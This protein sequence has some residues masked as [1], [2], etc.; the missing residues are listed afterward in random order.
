VR[1]CPSLRI[2]SI[3]LGLGLALG[4]PTE[5][6]ARAA[7]EA[8][9]D[10]VDGPIRY[11]AEKAEVQL[12]RQLKSDEA[13]A[14]FIER[15]WARRDPSPSSLSNEYRQM[16]W[17]RVR[18][19]NE[20]FLDSPRPGCMTDRGKI[21]VLY[22]PPTKIEEH[23]NLDTRSSPTAG[24]G[25]IR[26]VYEGRPGG[27]K[28]L[29]PVVIVPFVR[30]ATGEYRV[31]YDPK[32]SSV[33]FDALAVEERWDHA[34]DRF[35]EIFGAP[36]AT[37]MSVMLDLGRMQE[38]PPQA[39]VLL[40]RVET[41]EAYATQP[42]EVRLSRFFHPDERRDLVVV[43]ADVT[44]V[45]EGTTPV[46]VARFAPRDAARPQRMLGEDVFRLAHGVGRRLAQGRLLLDPGTYDLTVLVVDPATSVTG[47]KRTSLTLPEP[48]GRLRLSDLSWAAEL[49]PVEYG[50]LAS[51]DEPFLVGP[52]RVVPRFGDGF[53]LGDSLKLFYE[54]YGGTPPYRIAYQVEG[55]DLDGSWVELGRPAMTEQSAAG[56]GWELPTSSSWPLG[57]YRIRVDVEDAGRRSVSARLPFRLIAAIR[58]SDR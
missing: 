8:F 20:L 49:S 51:Y 13:R 52:F 10:W 6:P 31:S 39:R 58:A 9:A 29:A 35:R 18:Q 45:A 42:I 34:N 27:R 36:R 23:E 15:F 12:Y 11:I 22:G 53:A 21:Y 26:W 19:A 14:L 25:L 46:V 56:Q 5:G 3:A 17:E 30:Q 24:H 44:H 2:A 33:F 48:D 47:M 7:E 40:E 50:S 32:L 41:V 28:D 55:L 57:E 54:I 37:E 1:A 38:V 16:F 4:V 43:T